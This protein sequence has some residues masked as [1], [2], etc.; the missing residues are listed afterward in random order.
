M[1]G[2]FFLVRAYLQFGE[3]W[4]QDI[5]SLDPLWFGGEPTAVAETAVWICQ[6]ATWSR[7]EMMRG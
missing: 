1:E 7:R 2:S 5:S 3:L 6:R 4:G